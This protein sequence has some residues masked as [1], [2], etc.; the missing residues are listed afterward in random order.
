M[1]VSCAAR[2]LAAAASES[3]ATFTGSFCVFSTAPLLPEQP[4]NSS[5][6]KNGSKGKMDKGRMAYY[7]REWEIREAVT[8]KTAAE[9][10]Q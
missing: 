2:S 1:T 10:R 3:S 5:I 4:E 9:K 7:K 6:N 8:P